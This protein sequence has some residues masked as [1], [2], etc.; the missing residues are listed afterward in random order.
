MSKTDWDDHWSEVR[1]KTKTQQVKQTETQRIARLDSAE[2][3]NQRRDAH[4]TGFKNGYMQA[5]SELMA[6]FRHTSHYREPA[7]LTLLEDWHRRVKVWRKKA[8]TNDP[9]PELLWEKKGDFGQ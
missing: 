8:F 1:A 2:A 9:P 3:K 7:N 5:L 4:E 6:Y